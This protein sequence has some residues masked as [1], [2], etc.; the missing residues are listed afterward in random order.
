M[1]TTLLPAI[2]CNKPSQPKSNSRRKKVGSSHLHHKTLFIAT[3]SLLRYAPQWDLV[4][5]L[6]GAVWVPFAYSK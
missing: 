6:Q 4:K 5:P 3:I 1:A 2:K